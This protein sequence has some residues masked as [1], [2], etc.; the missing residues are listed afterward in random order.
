[1]WQSQNNFVEVGWYEEN[2]DLTICT[3]VSAPHFFAWAIVDGTKKCQLQSG[4][5]SISQGFHGFKVE[6]GNHNMNFT[7]WLDGNAQVTQSTSMTQGEVFAG[8]DRHVDGDHLGAEFDGLKWLGSAGGW[9]PW[10]QL[11]GVKYTQTWDNVSDFDFCWRS[12]Y[13]FEV[14]ANC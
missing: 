13:H 5:P 11:S 4:S 9:N 14:R 1:M 7:Y 6:D 8:V 12:N 2:V 3:D 10:N